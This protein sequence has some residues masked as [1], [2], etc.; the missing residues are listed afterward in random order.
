MK[1]DELVPVEVTGPAAQ[2]R[3]LRHK[4]YAEGGK[5]FFE[6][7]KVPD[8]PSSS[9]DRYHLVTS[10]EEGLRGLTL[11]SYE[12][13]NRVDYWWIIAA[14]NGIFHPSTDLKPGME[15]RIPSQQSVIDLTL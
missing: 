5:R 2:S 9:T 6:T 14:A 1:S 12:Y 3:F 7:W 11:I 10:G 8:I 13:Y 15:L 4:V